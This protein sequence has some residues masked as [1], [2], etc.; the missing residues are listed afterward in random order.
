MTKIHVQVMNGPTVPE[1]EVEIVERKGLGH[2][3]TICDAVMEQIAL[4]LSRAYREKF[5]AILHFNCD[6]GLL[7]AGQVKRR[8]GG[9][10]V[11]EPMRLIIGDRASVAMGKKRLDVAKIAVTTA[12]AWFQKN[13][14]RVNP[15]RHLRYQ[16]ELRPGSEELAALFS[17]KK[18]VLGANDTSAAVGY[19]PLTETEKMV[20]ETERYLN[21]S[22][23]KAGFPETGQDVKVM[24]I[25]SGRRLTLTVAMPLIDQYIGSEADYFRRKQAV[26]E[27]LMDHLQKQIEKLEEKFKKRGVWVVLIGRH[28]LGLRAQIFLVAGV[29]RMSATKFLLADGATSLFTIALMCGMGYAGGNSVEILKKNVKRIEHIAILILVILVTGWIVYRYFKTKKS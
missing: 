2:P 4:A 29:M 9:G 15:E 10:K 22:S 7:V 25:R 18:K 14:P 21:A 24:G 1:M 28:F 20:L 8:F 3:D 19:A 26:H 12:K 27:D 17:G 16:V 23:F 5:G 6:K 11:L 13:L